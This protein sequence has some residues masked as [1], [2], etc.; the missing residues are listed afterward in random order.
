MDVM[1]ATSRD[2]W[3]SKRDSMRTA[4]FPCAWLCALLAS[5]TA[6][7]EDVRPPDDQLFFPTGM[8]IASLDSVPVLFVANSNSELRYDSGAIAVIDVDLV[9]QAVVAWKAGNGELFRDDAVCSRDREHRETQV[10][11]EREFMIPSAGVRI[12]NF[13]T[14][15][16][17]QS[18]GTHLRVIVPTRGDPSITW[19]DFDGTRLTCAGGTAAF[20]LCDAEHR[21]SSVGDEGDGF[22]ILDEPFAV[23]AN[24]DGGFAVVTHLIAGAVTLVD[25]SG[26][27]RAQISDT[28]TNVFLAPPNIEPA[29]SAI[30]GRPRAG[31]GASDII[32][33]GSPTENR[34]Q[35]FTVAR[36]VNESAPYLVPGGYFL[37]DG[38]GSNS[39]GSSET[40]GMQF[41]AD[42]NRLFIANRRPPSLSIFDTS[43]GPTGVPRNV[44]TGST[45][46]CR[47]VATVEVFRL[48]DDNLDGERAY[49][50]CFQGG[51]VYVIDPRG[52]SQVEDVLTVGRGPYAAVALDE[53]GEPK[54]LFISNTLEDTIAVVD[55]DPRSAGYNRV[56]LRIGL[57]KEPGEP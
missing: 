36:P 9:K 55:V 48:G 38:V 5:C 52:Q 29:A 12:G 45:D 23:F 46:I 25:S 35:T 44:P 4:A 34:I 37:I 26:D 33:V 17:V 50:T 32:Y 28:V 16:A 3:W 57:P 27:R 47:E 2:F 56:V 30:A 31:E 6:S 41:S 40:R 42:G 14:D 22:P 1:Q 11:E 51:E 39:G 18:F 8:A 13:A 15:I 20:P 53:P 21:M 10:C 49:V 19:A 54:L 24:S 7:G 43:I